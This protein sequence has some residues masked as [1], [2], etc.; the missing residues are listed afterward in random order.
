MKKWFILLPV[1]LL[2]IIS[3]TGCSSSV[4]TQITFKNLA[5]NAVFVNFRA[6]IITVPS[7]QTVVVKDIPKGTF[8]YST[9]Y[10]IPANATN[11]T[12][13]GDVSGAF[14]ITQAGTKILV[15]YSSTFADGTYNLFAT[16]STNQDQTSPT[17]P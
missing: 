12:A 2:T 17:G 10:E 5:S 9:T 6:N 1:F 16:S 8:N 15:L 13:E 14:T 3:Y 4:G 7:G 11:S